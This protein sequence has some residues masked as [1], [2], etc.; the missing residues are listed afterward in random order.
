MWLS[1]SQ[2]SSVSIHFLIVGTQ[3]L[4]PRYTPLAN[5]FWAQMCAL[6]LCVQKCL[7]SSNSSPPKVHLLDSL[8][9]MGFCMHANDHFKG[10]DIWN[11]LEIS[12]ANYH[13]ERYTVL[14]ISFR[15]L[16]VSFA[17]H[18]PAHSQGISGLSWPE[19]ES[20][21]EKSW[22]SNMSFRTTSSM[23]V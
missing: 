23:T 19:R 8:L 5:D 20:R 22:G 21:D 10:L 3:I 2:G 16:L 12:K 18:D 9:L 1:A 4:W 6:S 14:D 11:T 13:V 17:A 7:H 15:Y